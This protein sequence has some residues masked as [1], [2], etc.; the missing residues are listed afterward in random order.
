[1]TN[2]KNYNQFIKDLFPFHIYFD[3]NLEIIEVGKSLL[4]IHDVEKH[5]SFTEY[6]SFER[7]FSVK[8][9]VKSVS[10]FINQ[11]FIIKSKINDK[12]LLRGQMILMDQNFLLFIG[13]PWINE[14]ETLSDLE[15]NLND[16]SLHDSTTDL[17]HLLKTKDIVSEDLERVT[18]VVKDQNQELL[19]Q[20]SI[21]DDIV[22]STN[23][24][25]WQWNVQTG[26]T[27]FNERWAEIIGCSL[28][29]LSPTNID[30]W[31]RYAYEPD[32]ELSSAKL[33][34]YFQ[35]ESENYDVELRM[36]HKNGDL[37]WVRDRGKVYSWTEDGKPEWM[38]GTHE[39]ISYRKSQEDSL[40]KQKLFYEGILNTIPSDIAV[41][42]EN[43]RY[44]FV[45]PIAI[46]DEK[47]REWIIGKDDFDY[48]KEFS[49]PVSLAKNRR[50]VFL[51]AKKG[52]PQIIEESLDYEN[53]KEYHLRHL[54][55][56]FDK[57]QRLKFVI[58][59][60]LN[61]TSIKQAQIEAEKARNE[62][63]KQKDS[64]QLL[65]S[66]LSHELRNPINS[67]IS[68]IS[69]YQDE[70]NDL[71]FDILNSLKVSAGNIDS[72]FKD[73]LI[74]END[75]Q[76][77]DL[78]T[79]NFIHFLKNFIDTYKYQFNKK[80]LNFDYE[81]DEDAD[82][83][84]LF[85]S[86]LLTQ[87]LSNLF[88]NALKYT[89]F[90]SILFS[91]KSIE[92]NDNNLK[93]EFSLKDTGIGI[94]KEML[95][96]IFDR[97]ER[98]P[99][100]KQFGVGLGLNIVKE[101]L[102]LLGGVIDVKSKIGEGSAFSFCLDFEIDQTN[103]L[104]TTSVFVSEEIEQSIFLI[105]DEVINFL[106]LEKLLLNRNFKL[107]YSDSGLKALDILHSSNFDY[108]LLDIKMPDISGFELLHRYILS[109]SFNNRTKLIAF[110]A[111]STKNLEDY[112]FEGFH[113]FIE[114]PLSIENLLEA[115]KVENFDYRF[116]D[117]NQIKKLVKNDKDLIFSLVE[118]FVNLLNQFFKIKIGNEGQHQLL[119]QVLHK[120]KGNIGYF[121]GAKMVKLVG[122]QYILLLNS[123]NLNYFYL[124]SKL[125]LL[126]TELEDFLKHD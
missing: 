7:P 55:P 125:L 12:L 69:L 79:I 22:D 8:P 21:L 5:K 97:Y 68:L 104:K 85:D 42:D 83:Q 117:L 114:K 27:I 121:S 67:I 24:G 19:I 72:I 9:N 26:E 11:L 99:N 3:N 4:K 77:T 45:N 31:L 106:I 66:T 60:G 76:P 18:Q 38:Y 82:C 74:S 1:M 36:K 87:I 123:E 102:K 41:F 46:K 63:E 73:I 84:L 120:I 81:F 28:E 94:P 71:D 65:L 40:L 115:L 34:M 124:A 57:N 70:N 98:V 118:D 14:I 54:F 10:E 88:S 6:F 49:K 122:E 53:G 48:C 30:T 25:V 20:K 103:L 37:I 95:T 32:L 96:K 61:I 52:T 51:R 56:V 50:E 78:S 80:G 62:A 23:M 16:F 44:L 90:G 75:Q 113:F 35:G 119:E 13:S 91:V 15:L 86:K 29:E 47:V 101:K 93:L 2:S 92:K 105:D 109:D 64:K 111:D 126:K 89:D 58:G 39:D 59:Y 17:L 43:H 107:K 116:F 108:L 110:S 33:E 112:R 100:D